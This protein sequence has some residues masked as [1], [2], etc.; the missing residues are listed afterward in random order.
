MN[1]TTLGSVTKYPMII[2]LTD[3]LAK[4]ND[5]QRIYITSFVNRFHIGIRNTRQIKDTKFR[6]YVL[7]LV[8]K[9]YLSMVDEF[10]EKYDNESMTYLKCF[11][12]AII[13]NETTHDTFK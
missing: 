13:R 9:D 7:S 11:I 8:R 12:V 5:N 10:M 1:Y 2:Q 3:N 4:M 6:D